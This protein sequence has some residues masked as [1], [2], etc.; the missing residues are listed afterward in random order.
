MALLAPA[1]LALAV[2]AR[3]ARRAMRMVHPA[4]VRAPAAAQEQARAQVRDL[5]EVTLRT[6]D[7]LTLRGWFSP[8]RR[9]AAVVLV[10]G[11]D[12][13]RAQLLAEALLLARAGYGFVAYDSRASGDSDGD[14]M[15]MGDHEQRDLAAALDFLAARPEIDPRRIAVLGFSI[16]GSTA[17]MTA[18]ADPRVAAVILYATWLSLEAE[19]KHKMRKY[20]ALS[21]GPTLFV[22]RQA[23]VDLARVR[24]I[25][26]LRAIAP[27]PLLMIAGTADEDTPLGIMQQL[28]ASAGPPKELWVVPGAGHGGYLDVAPTEYQARV[29]GFLDRTIGG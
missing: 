15:T 16:G 20:G 17:T 21:W 10:H 13:H 26:R 25:D 23:G 8:G 14:L 29:I 12:G 27:R 4:R 18:A 19:M 11:G 6:A 28:Y 9:R 1:G 2:V 7:G 5:E 22:L 3:A 24:P